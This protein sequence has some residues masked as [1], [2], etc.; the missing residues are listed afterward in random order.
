MENRELEELLKLTKKFAKFLKR[1]KQPNTLTMRTLDFENM[2]SYQLSKRM[3][4]RI[5]TITT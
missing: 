5:D 2:V 3:D 1:D 4:K